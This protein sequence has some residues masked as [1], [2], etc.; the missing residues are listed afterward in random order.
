[1][2]HNEKKITTRLITILLIFLA[3][4]TILFGV[5]LWYLF[6]QQSEKQNQEKRMQIL[7]LNEIEE[8]TKSDG[9]SPVAKQ[10]HMLQKELKN[11]QNVQESPNG[12]I[13]TAGYICSSVFLLLTFLY[14]YLTILKPFE[15]LQSFAAH[16]ARGDFDYSLDYERTNIFGAFTWAFDHMRREI[17]KAR[18]KEKEAIENNKTVIATLSHDIKTPIASIRTYA[19]ALEA[20]MDNSFERKSKYLTVIMNKCEEVTKLTNDLF[21]HSISDLD[22]LSIERNPVEMSLLLENTLNE[23]RETGMTIYCDTPLYSIWVLGDEK[24]LKQVFLNILGNADKYAKGKAVHVWMELFQGDY[25]RNAPDKKEGKL[26]CLHFKDEGEGVSPK[27]IPFLCD[28]F[29]RG[30]GTNMIPGAGL[31][32]F[33]INYVMEQLDG[34][35]EIKN[36]DDGLEIVLKIPYFMQEE[37]EARSISLS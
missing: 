35:V 9:K 3:M 30:T 37:M 24:R 15:K 10:I 19:E 22:K 6:P 26:L 18:S 28:K 8:K 25:V 21:L 23:Q 33:I 34:A 4:L 5:G 1:M 7:T 32:L 36:H 27:D 20:N 31:G 16:V 12:I 11:N 17:I 14:L 2:D 29:Y 13:L